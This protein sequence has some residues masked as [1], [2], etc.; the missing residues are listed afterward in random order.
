[1]CRL[2]RPE[3]AEGA[4]DD[5]PESAKVRYSAENPPNTTLWTATDDGWVLTSCAASL[6]AS[7]Q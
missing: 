5:T 2:P 4:N 1:M 7:Y 3:V 6:I